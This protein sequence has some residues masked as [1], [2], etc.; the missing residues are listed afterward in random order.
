MKKVL[1]VD[2]DPSMRWLL[3]TLLGNEY[4]VV[5]MSNGKEALSWLSTQNI[6]SLII[7]DIKMP[8]MDGFEL[9]ENL[10]ISGLYK[11][12]PVI[13]LTGFAD[14][15]TFKRCVD[16]GACLCLVKPFEPNELLDKVAHPLVSKMF[17]QQSQRYRLSN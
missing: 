6:P 7:S 5:T 10:A 14:Q 8:V 3:R 4:N 1:V 2:D 9:L 13:M 12:I 15:G 17:Y 11:N 16:L